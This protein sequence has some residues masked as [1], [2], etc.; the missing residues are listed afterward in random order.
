[1]K[2]SGVEKKAKKLRKF[3]FCQRLHLDRIQND[4]PSTPPK[5]A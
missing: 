3:C 4:G 2:I 1:M 5:L